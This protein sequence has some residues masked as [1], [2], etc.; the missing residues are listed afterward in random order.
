MVSDPEFQFDWRELD[1]KCPYWFDDTFPC[2]LS[3]AH[4]LA[5]GYP[6]R[7][8]ANALAVHL[9]QDV[10]IYE[11]KPRIMAFVRL[12]REMCKGEEEDVEKE[13]VKPA[14]AAPLDIAALFDGTEQREFTE[15]ACAAGFDITTHPLKWLFSNERTAA[16][17]QGWSAGIQHA[18]ARLLSIQ[19]PAPPEPSPPSPGK[20][21]TP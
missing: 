18:R 5:L 4:V 11:D 16:A 8:Y 10:L 21:L 2:K 6:V 1:P 9:D 14:H 3:A 17:R 7:E 15:W 12:E 20:H 13:D 19:A